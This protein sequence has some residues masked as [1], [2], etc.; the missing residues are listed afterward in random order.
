[1]WSWQFELLLDVLQLIFPLELIGKSEAALGREVR[2]WHDSHP[3]LCTGVALLGRA[4]PAITEVEVVGSAKLAAEVECP[5]DGLCQLILL[6]LLVRDEDDVLVEIL[7]AEEE[8]TEPLEIAIEVTPV[9]EFDALRWRTCAERFVK[10][11]FAQGGE[12]VENDSLN[13]RIDKHLLKLPNE[14]VPHCLGLECLALVI[15]A[16]VDNLNLVAHLL[17][18]LTQPGDVVV[19]VKDDRRGEVSG[20]GGLSCSCDTFEQESEWTFSV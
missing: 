16:R 17:G 12:R 14:V 6:H 13:A 3:E 19:K 4:P 1:M 5:D 15:G 10:N 8:V 18:Q 7:C 9:L 20:F 11:D 2:A